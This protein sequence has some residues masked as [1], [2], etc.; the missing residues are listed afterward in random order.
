MTGAVEAWCL[1]TGMDQSI[2]IP[3]D[4]MREYVISPS[5]VYIPSAPDYCN[6][7]CLWQNLVIPIMDLGILAGN[8]ESTSTAGIVIISYYEKEKTNSVI[9]HSGFNV[10]APPTK[11]LIHNQ[12]LVDL[13]DDYNSTLLPTVTSCFE[14]NGQLIYVHNIAHLFSRVL[15]ESVIAA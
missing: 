9:K 5:L 2:A 7:M 11:L 15:R 14:H 12:E 1:K 4:Y 6:T 3:I 8:P 13:P 10:Y